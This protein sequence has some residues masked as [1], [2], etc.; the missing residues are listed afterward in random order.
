M[1]ECE[2]LGL[3]TYEKGRGTEIFGAPGI[4]QP[5]IPVDICS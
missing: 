3:R 5:K 1:E 2:L 4:V